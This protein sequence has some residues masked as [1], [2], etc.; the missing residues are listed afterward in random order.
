MGPGMKI[1][2]LSKPAPP[3]LRGGVLAIGNF[4]GV[5]KGHQALIAKARRQ[6][7]HHGTT[8]NVLTFSPHPRRFFKPNQ[9]GFALSCMGI[10][11]ERLAGF[12][13]DNM[14]VQPF[15]SD[16]A[17]R[18]PGWFAESF[19]KRDLGVVHVVVGEDFHFGARRAGDVDMLRKLGRTFGFGVT[20]VGKTACC[21]GRTYS[22]TR[23]REALCDANVSEATDVLGQPWE[24]PGPRA[25]AQLGFQRP[26]PGEYVV[27]LS[28]DGQQE[29]FGT[30]RFDRKGGDRA[31]EAYTLDHPHSGAAAN[32]RVR[33]L[34]YLTA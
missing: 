29:Q 14:F 9:P 20:A 16:Y 6:A 23:V 34:E 18:T 8:A 32:L 22:S 31:E 4:D 13:V 10:R 17:A 2:K 11:A 1:H 19:L 3:E 28:W 12:G 25:F 27:G 21:R 7:E 33:V 30:I 26:R 15:T 24:I 5:H